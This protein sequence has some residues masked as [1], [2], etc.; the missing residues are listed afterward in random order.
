MPVRFICRRQ[1]ELALKVAH[2]DSVLPV[3]VPSVYASGV[4]FWQLARL[5]VRLA[6]PELF[7]GRIV[8]VMAAAASL[9]AS[10]SPI[11]TSAPATG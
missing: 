7:S 6:S 3:K 9:A 5:T 1:S 4:W 8:M 10:A 11:A 2:T